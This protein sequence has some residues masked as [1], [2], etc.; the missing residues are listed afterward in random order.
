MKK[1]DTVKRIVIEIN[2][3]K[4]K[5]FIIDPIHGVR[6]IDGVMI[7]GSK[8]GKDNKTYLMKHGSNKSIAFAFGSSYGT[9]KQLAY[10][11][12]P[13]GMDIEDLYGMMAKEMAKT[14][15]NEIIEEIEDERRIDMEELK[16]IIGESGESDT[17]R[18]FEERLKQFCKCALGGCDK[19][20]TH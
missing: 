12:D 11:D 5:I 17:R 1:E 9:A 16:S 14:I 6:E 2:E 18:E 10:H 3:D 15:P 19:D 8:T 4:H 13:E 7:I 20:T